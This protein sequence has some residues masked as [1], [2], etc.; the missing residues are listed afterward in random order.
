MNNKLTQ[1][2]LQQIQDLRKQA[3][4]FASA[5]GELGYQEVLISLDKAK[6]T[7]SVK[8]LKEKE[9][10]LFDEF[11]KKYGNGVID[12]ETGDIQPRQ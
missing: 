10:V 4:E 3:L 12:L 2:E 6:L 1:E 8:E 11:G 5:L 7:N 9:R